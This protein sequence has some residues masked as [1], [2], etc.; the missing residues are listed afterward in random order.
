MKRILH[1]PNYSITKD[2]K[3]FSHNTKS[4]LI[5]FNNRG[6]LRVGLSN[7]NKHKKF[8]VHRLVAEA[9]LPN[10]NNNKIVNHIDGNKQNNNISNLEWTTYSE[11]SKHAYRIGLYTDIS[12]AGV[13]GKR[14]IKF[15][16]KANEKIILN[17]QTGIF[18]ESI[19]EAA[20]LLGYKYNNLSQYLRGKNK[21][22]TNLIYA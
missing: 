21:N 19:K 8:L 9:F 15:A 20:E 7:K 12:K 6:Y 5:P 14:T 2:G 17:T 10:N 16:Q 22:K 11:N 4:Y 1:Y 18:Y 3:V 13:Y